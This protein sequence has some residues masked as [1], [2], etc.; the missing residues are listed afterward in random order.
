MNLPTNTH[1]A[2]PIPFEHE[3]IEKRY[4]MSLEEEDIKLQYKHLNLM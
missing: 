1:K 2:K 4:I 3:D